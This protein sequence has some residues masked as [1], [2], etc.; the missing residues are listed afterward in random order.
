[1]VTLFL[2][3]LVFVFAGAESYAADAVFDENTTQLQN[4]YRYFVN[5]HV[6]VDSRIEV[7]GKATINLRSGATLD[8]AMG[9]H[10]PSGSE[11][12]VEGT[13]GT[14]NAYIDS[15]TATGMAGIGA[16]TR[17]DGGNIT[18]R[19]GANVT[20]TGANYGAGIGGGIENEYTGTVYIS[21]GTVTATGGK[22]AAG[23]GSG[24][25]KGGVPARFKGKIIITGGKVT[26]SSTEE[27]Y[28]HN[29]SLVVLSGAGIGAGYESD[30]QGK[31]EISGGEVTATGGTD[32][33]GIGA[34]KEGNA[35]D[36]E[37]LISGGT[38]TATGK[39][40][41]AGIG[42]GKEGG[43]PHWVGGEG[44]YVHIS[45]GTVIANSDFCAIGHGKNDR[46]MGTLVIDDIM[47]VQAGNN[48]TD[49]ERTFTAR[50][51][52]DACHYRRCAR[53]EVCDHP[54]STYVSDEEGHRLPCQY[55][56][57]TLN[58]E[59]HVFAEVEGSAVD[60]SCVTPGKTADQKCEI[61]G[62]VQAGDYTGYGD[63]NWGEVT[64]SWSDDNSEVTASR[65]CRRDPEHVDGET[66][67]AS[68]E[69]KAATCEEPG[70]ITYTA[71]FKNDLFETQKKTVE[72][73]PAL[74]HAWGEWE[75]TK[76]PTK[77]AEGEE[78]RVCGND[79][80]HFELRPIP[81]LE[82]THVLSYV[83]ESAASCTTSG[84]RAYYEC[85]ADGC[86]AI[87]E[88]EAGTVQTSAESIKIPAKGHKAGTP[89]KGAETQADCCYV[90]GYNLT[91]K[92]ETCGSV[93]GI[94]HVV[95]PIDPD[96]HVWDEGVVTREASETETGIRTY[97]CL[98][99]SSHTRTEVIPKITPS[100]PAEAAPAAA[101]EV[102]D[103]SLPKVKNIKP[104]GGKASL[105]AK[106]KKLSKKNIKKIQGIEIQY[107]TDK[108]FPDGQ[109]GTVNAGKKAKTKKIRKLAKKTTYYT[110]V[111][112]YKYID[113]V[114]HVSSWS[115]VKKNKTK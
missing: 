17:Q 41:G 111:R 37:V 115:A 79:P 60:A 75:K 88:D 102:L 51:Q 92:C 95:F 81:K 62:Y 57:S 25:Y 6:E 59:L 65:V 44:A 2:A 21:G 11:L 43:F 73:D 56:Y 49:Y 34:G 84:H 8:A 14:L 78:K 12:I 98:N 46:E 101:S 36:G 114:K 69:T 10:V 86:T 20:A 64:Y 58:K 67:S 66:A 76:D 96:T 39:G 74:G 94:E 15:D 33:A 61:C 55:C 93:L 113:G 91:T 45:G 42:G 70:T 9:I 32:S 97:T 23:I 109:T 90:G 77:E 52:T 5:G 54:D 18:I 27:R 35:S 103:P 38:V 89:V 22:N 1:M 50:E 100:A 7:S 107:S 31:I 71:V 112:T 110:R 13:G 29:G 26:A 104:A 105:K 99:D 30:M 40:G 108:S 72:T 28:Y 106:W 63:H 85:T 16:N 80:S 53:I 19:N 24:S 47:K 68:S 82:H 3:I 48:G 4:G 87:F 83:E